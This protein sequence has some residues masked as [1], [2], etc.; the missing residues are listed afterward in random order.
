M[1]TKRSFVDAMVNANQGL[2]LTC[3][4]E[5]VAVSL[6]TS[7]LLRAQV[8]S[9]FFSLSLSLNDALIASQITA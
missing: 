7:A 8:S 2:L 9:F 3:A 6:L 1:D 4:C 5:T